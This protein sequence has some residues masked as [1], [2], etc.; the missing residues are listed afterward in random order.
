MSV[1]G[2][3]LPRIKSPLRY[4]TFVVIITSLIAAII[5]TDPF[6]QLPLTLFLQSKGY[7]IVQ[8]FFFVRRNMHAYYHNSENT[9]SP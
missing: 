7:I 4:K 2:I 3:V 8:H 1:T 9:D 5:I 6:A